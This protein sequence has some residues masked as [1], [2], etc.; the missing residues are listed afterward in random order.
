MIS[1]IWTRFQEPCMLRWWHTNGLEKYRKWISNYAQQLFGRSSFRFDLHTSARLPS[2]KAQSPFKR[3]PLVTWMERV[4]QRSVTRAVVFL[5]KHPH[6][7]FSKVGPKYSGLQRL[8]PV[9]ARF[10][11]ETV[12]H[13]QDS[14]PRNTIDATY[15]AFLNLKGVCFGVPFSSRQQFLDALL[16]WSEGSCAYFTSVAI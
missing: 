6:T 7:Q 16:C 10:S 1:R 14:G 3:L 12:Q 2:A 15:F 11:L 8:L 5:W 13:A 9:T 4:A